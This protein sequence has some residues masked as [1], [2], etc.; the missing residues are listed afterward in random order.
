MR[1]PILLL[2]RKLLP[3]CP[4]T[5]HPCNLAKLPTNLL[6]SPLIRSSTCI[7]SVRELIVRPVLLSLFVPSVLMDILLIVLETVPNNPIIQ[8]IPQTTPTIQPIPQ[9]TQIPPIIPPIRPQIPQIP[10]ITLQ[11]PRIIPIIQLIPPPIIQI[12][13]TI[14]RIIP[15]VPPPTIPQ[16]ALQILQMG[17]KLRIPHA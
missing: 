2:W 11:I 9:T 1:P 15:I 14:Q 5:L 8:P 17:I 12:P 16:I 10:Q 7:L 4:A 3:D 6:L 13:Q